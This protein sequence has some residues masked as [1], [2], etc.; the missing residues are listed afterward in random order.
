MGSVTHFPA[1]RNGFSNLIDSLLAY[2]RWTGIG[3]T[4]S[5]ANEMRLA[6]LSESFAPLDAAGG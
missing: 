4:G 6:G 1:Y 5:D 3:L 2:S